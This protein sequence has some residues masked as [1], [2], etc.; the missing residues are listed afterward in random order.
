MHPLHADDLMPLACSRED[1]CCADATVRLTPWEL[2]VLA[3]GTG[4]TPRAFRERHTVA[5]GTQLRFAGSPDRIGRT[6][7][8]MH[9]IGQ[10]CSVHGARPLACRLF[11]LGSTRVA[12]VRTY[13]HPG[14]AKSCAELCPAS[15]ALPPVR[16]GDY[17][18]GQQV[19]AAELA[20]DGYAATL[21]AIIATAGEI[22]QR[23]GD[24]FD[25]ARLQ[26]HLA[27]LL[28]AD[29]QGRARLL[30]PRILD[31]L[32]LPA[33]TT[34]LER[35]ADFVAEHRV[36]IAAGVAHGFDLAS[37]QEV[38]HALLGMGFLLAPVLGTDPGLV[39]AAFN[40]QAHLEAA[41]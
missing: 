9:I 35:P 38:V 24:G 3:Q 14:R 23:S 22:T 29:A 16:V 19:A 40:A 18:A 12:G 2:A 26:A 25:S 28:A 1:S 17:L 13:H 34:T 41:A 4:M 11:P 36:L 39:V 32:T 27:T 5:G 33:C 31:L 30:P 10:G 7:C 21:A 8:D 15:R 20:H 37:H 6:R